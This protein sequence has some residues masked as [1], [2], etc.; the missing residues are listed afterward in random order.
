MSVEIAALSG[1]ALV[2]AL[3]DLAR[4]RISVFRDFP[5][6]YDGSLEY[7]QSYL[8]SYHDNPK[9]VLVAAMDASRIVGAATG[10]PLTDHGDA[11]QLQGLAQPIEQV[12]YC[13]ES[14]LLPAYR[15]QGVGH[16]FFDEREAFA[17]R[18]GF[19]TSAFCGVIRAA[20]HPMRPADYRPLDSFWQKRGYAPLPGVQAR[21][22]WTDVGDAAPTTK[23]LQFWS[24]AL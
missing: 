19:K 1:D 14:V 20:D 13:A 15:G 24:R 5:Y 18:L 3:P 22:T 2:A 10:M 4:L 21:Y 8:K 16:A 17:R 7:E 12:F 9:A 23:D 6:L 11:G